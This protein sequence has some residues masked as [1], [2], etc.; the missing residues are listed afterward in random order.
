[1][2]NP[3]TVSCTAPELDDL[4]VEVEPGSHHSGVTDPVV[5][6]KLRA[7]L[8]GIVAHIYG[9]TKGE[10]AYVLSTFPLMAEPIKVAA[11]EAYQDVER[12]LVT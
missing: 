7:D 2:R 8:D 11:L 10:F 6:A 3:Y 12:G 4:A 1:M 9:L 5:R